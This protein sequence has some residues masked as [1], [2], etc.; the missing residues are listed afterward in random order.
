[1]R[2]VVVRRRFGSVQPVCRRGTRSAS[3]RPHL[4]PHGESHAPWLDNYASVADAGA[5]WWRDASNPS[6]QCALSSSAWLAH[7]L[8]WQDLPHRGGRGRAGTL[9]RSGHR[10]ATASGV[11]QPELATLLTTVYLI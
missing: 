8:L 1:M 7:D 3:A 5:Q 11:C 4:R 6:L 2:I 9:G 10:H